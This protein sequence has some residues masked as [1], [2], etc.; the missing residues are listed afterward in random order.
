MIEEGYFQKYKAEPIKLQPKN[1]ITMKKIGIICDDY[2]VEMFKQELTA[3]GVTFEIEDKMQ[4]IAKGYTAITCI[5]EQHIIGPITEK[6][7]RYW[8][9]HFKRQRE[10]N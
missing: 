1:N 10:Q 9:E 7:T 5:S 8:S 3:A 4:K 2:K 6:V